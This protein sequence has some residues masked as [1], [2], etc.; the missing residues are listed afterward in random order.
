MLNH[1]NCLQPKH[2]N[3]HRSKIY[4]I[5]VTIIKNKIISRIFKIMLY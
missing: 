4:Y 3:Y 5:N 1:L 2:V